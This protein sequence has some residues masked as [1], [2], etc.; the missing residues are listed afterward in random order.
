YA[1]ETVR[2]LID[3]DVVVPKGGVYRVVGDVGDLDV[4][5]TLTSLIAARIDAL[6]AE[7]RA[8]VKD[9]AVVRGGFARATAAAV[10]SLDDATLDQCLSD[11]VRKEFLSVRTDKLSPDRGQYVFAQSLLRTVAYDMLSRR[12]RKAHHLAVAEHLRSTFE[13]DGEDVSEVIAVH[14]RDALLAAAQDADATEIRHEAL[15]AYGRA[16]RRAA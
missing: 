10:C 2:S 1:V 6:P 9:L 5:A 16:G 11:L 4:P 3:R 14:Y 15:T 7:Q 8:L 13:N 12:E